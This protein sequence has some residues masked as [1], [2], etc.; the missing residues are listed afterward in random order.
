METDII[1]VFESLD[2]QPDAPLT[3]PEKDVF[4]QIRNV[5]ARKL[6]PLVVANDGSVKKDL[7][8]ARKR[9]LH[10]VKR[11]LLEMKSLTKSLD[12]SDDDEDDHPQ[13][14]D[15]IP[16][17]DSVSLDHDYVTQY[18]IIPDLSSD[19]DDEKE[20]NEKETKTAYEDPA[21]RPL[22]MPS[23]GGIDSLPDMKSQ[24]KTEIEVVIESEEEDSSEVI[25]RIK[26][27]QREYNNIRYRRTKNKQLDYPVYLG[28][29]LKRL[30]IKSSKRRISRVKL[31][32]IETG[33][34]I[35]KT[36]KKT[37]TTPLTKVTP[38]L[39]MS[40]L[41][42][43]DHKIAKSI[44]VYERDMKEQIQESDERFALLNEVVELRKKLAEKESALKLKK[45][46]RTPK[47][48]PSRSNAENCLGS[49][50]EASSLE[51]PVS[52]TTSLFCPSQT[53]NLSLSRV[54]SPSPSHTSLGPVPSPSP[55]CESIA[56]SLPTSIRSSKPYESYIDTVMKRE[57]LQ[58]SKASSSGCSQSGYSSRAS[59]V[60]SPKRG[61]MEIN[62][63]KVTQ[64]VLLW[65]DRHPVDDSEPRTPP[66]PLYWSENAS[67]INEPYSPI[68]FDDLD[69]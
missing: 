34:R 12:E 49:I 64:K 48:I 40:K 45:R 53:N 65:K 24:P 28:E 52:L 4:T 17:F 10:E 60:M 68:N 8:D 6:C 1:R 26:M 5:L 63:K 41:S 25:E 61:K 46:T 20:I 69:F 55:S 7:D 57:G 13:E 3:Q 36:F 30:L 29:E 18:S 21:K 56:L 22:S 31:I 23:L 2:S 32:S 44:E 33:V 37:A 11:I 14:Q 51:S 47:R 62:S 42:R 39:P 27:D 16:V 66:T 59:S 15:C 50:G 43:I 54:S 38:T 58:S 9:K 35:Q 67:D 19:D